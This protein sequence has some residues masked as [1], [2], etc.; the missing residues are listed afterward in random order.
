MAASHM[1]L[2]LCVGVAVSASLLFIPD[3]VADVAVCAP[4][5]PAAFDA[6][7]VALFWLALPLFVGRP[8]C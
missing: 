3:A 2:T 4:P 6:E 5:F 7:P 1:E 8:G